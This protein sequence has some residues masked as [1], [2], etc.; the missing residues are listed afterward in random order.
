MRR[1]IQENTGRKRNHSNFLDKTSIFKSQIKT[2]GSDKHQI[3][4]KTT[5]QIKVQNPGKDLGFILAISLKKCK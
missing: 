2:I 3:S 4:T 5:S 1:R